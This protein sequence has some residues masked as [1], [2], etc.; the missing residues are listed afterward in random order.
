[1]PDTHTEVTRNTWESR[2]RKSSN[3]VLVGLAL[4]PLCLWWLWTNEGRPDLSTLAQ[5]SVAVAS[6]T[7]DASKDGLFASISG[8]LISTEQL[9][10]TPYMMPNNYIALIRTSEMYAWNETVDSSEAVDNVG[11]RSTTTT[12]Y[13]YDT[14]WTTS[15]QS[16]GSFKFAEGHENPS[17]SIESAYLT[18]TSAHVGA[19][20]IDPTTITLPEGQAVDVQPDTNIADYGFVQ[21]GNFLY[22]GSPSNPNVGDM[23]LS[24]KALPNAIA[25]TVF[26]KINSGTIDPYTDRL[27]ANFSRTMYRVFLGSRDDAIALLQAEYVHEVWVNRMLG[28]VGLWIALGLLTDPIIKIL[29]G[30]KIVGSAVTAI[31]QTVNIVVAL[32]VGGTT[33]II[34]MV[35]HN[36][37][38]LIGVIAFILIGVLVYLRAHYGETESD[39]QITVGSKELAK[40]NQHTDTTSSS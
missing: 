39:K 33:I 12:N 15:P 8:T 38:L 24:Y 17:K 36:L 35:F 13:T 21:D 40:T 1:M 10:D 20:Q 7:I 4:I 27:D 5:Q 37:Y 2:I 26:G 28:V 29:D 14:G 32:T 19:Y 22:N 3:N 9:G 18:V 23:R 6:N 34:S 30:I 25:V 31:M 11:G 16:S